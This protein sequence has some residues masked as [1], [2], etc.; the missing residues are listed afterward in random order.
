MII[1]TSHKQACGQDSSSENK[2]LMKG[3]RFMRY[4]KVPLPK[5][6][7]SG[8]IPYA[9]NFFSPNPKRLLGLVK[10]GLQYLENSSCLRFEEQDPVKAAQLEDYTYLY[11][12]YSGV[13]EDCCLK[14]YTKE[15][16]RRTVLITPVCS[17]THEIA[18]ATLHGLGASHPP[19]EPFSETTVGA[20][21]QGW[22]QQFTSVVTTT[23]YETST[24]SKQYLKKNTRSK[25]RWVGLHGLKKSANDSKIQV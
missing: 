23:P 1:K 10:K 6:W 15:Y 8:T 18:H 13:S 24:S 11:F 20:V 5:D 17:N 19:G 25:H 4:E 7:M 9:L 2:K 12:T 22:C 3:M 21:T 16:G 14:Y